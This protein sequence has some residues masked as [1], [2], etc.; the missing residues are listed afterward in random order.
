MKHTGFYVEF[1]NNIFCR[2]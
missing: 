2:K 1:H